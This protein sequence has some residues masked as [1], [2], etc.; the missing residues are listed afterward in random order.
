MTLHM[1]Q[2]CIDLK[3]G[4]RLH[5]NIAKFQTIWNT[6]TLSSL[7]RDYMGSYCGSHYCRETR[8]RQLQPSGV[9][10]LESDHYTSTWVKLWNSTLPKDQKSSW[11]LYFSLYRLPLPILCVF[12]Q[13]TR[14]MCQ[15]KGGNVAYVI[16]YAVCPRQHVVNYCWGYKTTYFSYDFK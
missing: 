6:H 11:N 10:K 1:L 2:F 4:R 9:H 16:N 13:V 3:F 14:A 15:P 5:S 8:L 7:L 12:S